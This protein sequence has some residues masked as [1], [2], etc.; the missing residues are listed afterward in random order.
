M[1][2]GFEVQASANVSSTITIRINFKSTYSLSTNRKIFMHIPYINIDELNK[3]GLI[4]STS[5]SSSTPQIF[6]SLTKSDSPNKSSEITYDNNLTIRFRDTLQTIE[7]GYELT[8]KITTINQ[9]NIT[10]LSSSANISFATSSYF[11]S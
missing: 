2:E 1:Y 8:F 3:L 9:A 10:T 11:I 4:V 5:E 6:V 7:E